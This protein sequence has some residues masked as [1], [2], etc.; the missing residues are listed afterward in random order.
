MMA[1]KP[2]FRFALRAFHFS[3]SAALLAAGCT[4]RDHLHFPEHPVSQSP[5]AVVFDTDFNRAPDFALL[6]DGPDE[7][8]GGRLAFDDDEDGTPD[9]L[10]DLAEYADDDVPHLVVLLDSIPFASLRDRHAADPRMSV[11]GPPVKVIAPYPS[12]SA[13]CFS[14]ILHAPPM[15]GPINRHYDPRPQHHGVTNLIAKRLGGHRNPWQQRLH[16]N[17]GY[18]DNT[19]AFLKPRPWMKAEFARALQS[20]DASPDLNTF[21]YISSTASMLFKYGEPALDEVFDELNRFVAQVLYERRGAVKISVVADHGHNL[22]KTRWV[23]V[24]EHLED[25]GFRVTKK[26]RFPERPDDVYLEQDGLLTWFG[27]HTVRPEAVTDHLLTLPEIETVAHVRGEDVVVRTPAGE[28]RIAKRDHQFTYTPVRGNPLAFPA[29]LCD[30]PL[31]ADDWFHRTADL[32]FPDGAVRLWDAFHG[33]TR[34]TPQVMATLQDGTCAGIGW[35]LWFVDPHSTHGGL[36]QVNSAT[37]AM[38]MTGRLDGV[39]PLRSREVM[40][41][42]MP[43]GPPRIVSD[44]HE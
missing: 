43:E 21:V 3:L 32:A 33:G 19:N 7:P 15:P 1:T 11:F 39:G 36:N 28:A 23:D 12:M 27:V 4:P 10:F 30:V 42:L 37:C 13:V 22:M 14:D 38:T 5:A 24:E 18:R 31:S 40:G 8:R 16:Y 17:I 44:N 34:Q 9:R 29:E 26:P 41:L 20:F 25:G 35:F 2:P 6:T